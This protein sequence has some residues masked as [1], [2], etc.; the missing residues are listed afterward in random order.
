[1]CAPRLKQAFVLGR[2]NVSAPT[3][4]QALPYVIV[5]VHQEAHQRKFGMN[6]DG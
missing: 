3:L 1:M 6:A 5:I 2:T 4:I